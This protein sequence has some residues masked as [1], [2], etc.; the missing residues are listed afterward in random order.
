MKKLMLLFFIVISICS[1]NF[2]NK[3]NKEVNDFILLNRNI[4]TYYKK[5][6]NIIYSKLKDD[7]LFFFENIEDRLIKYTLIK[8]Y[9]VFLN[10]NYNLS[11]QGNFYI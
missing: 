7:E 5:D 1:L 11:Y 9:N 6:V 2:T 3:M 8:N 4:E 10:I